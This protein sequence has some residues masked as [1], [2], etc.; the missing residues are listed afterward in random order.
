MAKQ[1]CVLNDCGVVACTTVAVFSYVYEYFARVGL[2][3]TLRFAS[4]AKVTKLDSTTV[5]RALNY[6]SKVIKVTVT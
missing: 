6:L 5:R 3:I 1:P 2:M 4:N